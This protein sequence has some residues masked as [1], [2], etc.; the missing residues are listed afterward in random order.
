MTRIEWTRGD[1]GTA[2]K[3]WNVVTGCS[4][5]CDYCYARRMARRLQAMGQPRYANGFA[6]TFHPEVLEEPLKWRKPRR[7]FVVSMGDLF[8]PA[9]TDKQIAAV[10]GVMAACQR[11]TFQV[12]TKQA[13]RMREWLG[14]LDVSLCP[15]LRCERCAMEN[16]VALTFGQCRRTGVDGTWPLNNTW[17]GTTVETRSALHRVDALRQCPAAVRFISFEPLQERIGD[18]DLTGIGWVIV[19]ANSTRGATEMRK[20]WVRDIRDQCIA[21]SVPFF[22]KARVENGTRVSLPE[23][24]GRT[25]EQFPEVR[26]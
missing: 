9:I 18:I 2:G 17:L 8:D 10:F 13:M 26:R 19:G 7:V 21:K 24:D 20:A 22:Y 3:S 25:W 12:L 4:C 15:L 6:P 1:D 14:W 11:H 16:G 23:L 5:G